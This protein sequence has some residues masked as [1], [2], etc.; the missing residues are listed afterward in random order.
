[1][2]RPPSSPFSDART[3]RWGAGPVPLTA[4]FGDDDRRLRTGGIGARAAVLRDRSVSF[5]VGVESDAPYV[6]RARALGLPAVARSTGG[7]GLLHEAGDIVW[8]VVIPRGHPALQRGF[9]RAYPSLGAGTI[10]GLSELGVE[11][12]WEP[13]PGDSATYCTLGSRGSVL[14]VR[15]RILGG[16]AQHL[17]GAH[18]LHHGVVSGHVD[19][20]AVAQ[21]F[22]LPR[23][24]PV[25]RLG[26][27]IDVG[28][29]AAPADVADAVRHGLA[30]DLAIPRLP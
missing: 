26:G 25:A 1:M 7:T 29:A 6:R 23:N 28:C 22:D 5:G 27:L 18:L 16:A 10:A 14:S 19:S 20:A 15:G 8:S 13:A 2:S 3:A 11:A 24:G 12:R 9:T 21:I 17:T 4:F 30:R